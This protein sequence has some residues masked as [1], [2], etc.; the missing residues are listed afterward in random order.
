MNKTTQPIISIIVPLYNSFQTLSATINSILKQELQDFEIIIV[1]DGS[2]DKSTN[3]ALNWQK[4]DS[5]IKY[6]FQENK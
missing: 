6:L 4:K 5:R 2:T 3:L 1:N